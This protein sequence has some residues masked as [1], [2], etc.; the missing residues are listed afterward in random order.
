MKKPLVEFYDGEPWFDNP[1]LIVA[2]IPRRKRRST[3][4]ARPNRR[5]S[6]RHNRRHRARHNLYSPGPLVNPHRRR[7]H[8]ANPFRLNRRHRRHGWRYRQ[9]LRFNRRHYRQNPGGFSLAGV[10]LPP[11]DAVLWVGSGLILPPLVTAQVMKFIPASWQQSQAT[12]W[13][14]KVASIVVPGIL[15]RKF[16]N[17]RAGNLFMVGGLASLVLDAIRTYAPGM[18]PGVGRY[19]GYQPLLGAYFGPGAAAQT[20]RPSLPSMLSDAPTRLDP[21]HRF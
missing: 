4:M 8:R 6:I 1:Q 7:R 12:T 15:L 19:M 13:L 14:V 9:N 11:I 2:N 20:P 21:Q 18:L 3:T 16:V 17:P 5:H 10:Q